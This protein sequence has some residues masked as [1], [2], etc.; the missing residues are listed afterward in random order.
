VSFLI[1]T[2][3]VLISSKNFA[4]LL[5]LVVCFGLSYVIPLRMPDNK[6]LTWTLR[7][8]I[9]TLLITFGPRRHSSMASVLY[10]PDYVYLAG[11]LCVSEFTLRSWIEAPRG[12]NRTE[13]FLLT[14][15][16]F[17]T[18]TN[19][20]ETLHINVL[21]PLYIVSLIFMFRAF[22]RRE[23]LPTP[24]LKRLIGM[25]ALA[26]L[27]A[28]AMAATAIFTVRKF[29]N[30]ITYWA[31]HL[32]RNRHQRAV[33]VGL[34]SSPR[35]QAVFNPAQSLARVLLIDGPP[36][37]R[38]LRAMAFTRYEGRRWGNFTGERSLETVDLSG[39][40]VPENSRELTITRL[41]NT[42]AWLPVPLTTAR[43]QMEGE[44]HGDDLGVLNT[45]EAEAG[46]V[47]TAT[48]ATS[49]TFQGPLCRPPAQDN[50]EQL[51]SVPDEIDRRVI[52]LAQR[53]GGSDDPLTRVRKLEMYLRSTHQYSLVYDPGKTEPLSDF[54]LNNR[55]A[56]CQY[57][58][59]AMVMLSRAAG[60]PARL[61][62]GYYAHE[63]YTQNQMVVR[64]RDAHAWAECFIPKLGWITMDAT[65]SSGR[66][67]QL[68]PEPS[69]WRRLWE[70]IQDVPA[71][72][73]AWFSNLSR[74]T[75]LTV[76][77]SFSALA[78]TVAGIRSLILRLRGPRTAP[79]RTYAPP[80]VE[81][82]AAARRFEKVLS[83]RAVPCPPDR[84]WRDHLREPKAAAALDQT[85]ARQFIDTY[86]AARFG[87]TSD[88]PGAEL[89][90]L[91]KQLEQPT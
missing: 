71:R 7:A 45:P 78:L 76:V 69:A 2:L 90:D 72:V 61:V 55:A 6:V 49:D 65:P 89:D 42:L 5:P 35:L 29:E 81:L 46:S 50:M 73:R 47:Y 82:Q 9:W 15:L 26:A 8:L 12:P 60:V 91:L 51:L 87:E 52:D 4:Q 30:Q 38:H 13:A 11:V 84:T 62:T 20:Y 75:V 59:S 64:D 28:M 14:A 86:N 36:S 88:N 40:P 24:H 33:E 34:N 80:T 41:T 57:F 39:F 1:A 54:I 44:M 85:A 3:A 16:I 27:L 67:D 53:V 37:E 63:R 19:T 23:Q 22:S 31:V 17:A 83:A 70:R 58:A 25:R 21:S 74:Q 32:A 66:P 48:V 10:E 79:V 43:V 18:A 68:F 56:H 77:F